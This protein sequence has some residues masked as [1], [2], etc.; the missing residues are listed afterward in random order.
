MASAP[1]AAVYG[2]LSCEQ[3]RELA[4]AGVVLAT[5][6]IEDGQHQPASLDLRLGPTAYRVRASFL[7]GKR[8]SVE[9]LLAELTYDEIGL[10]G[11]GAVLERGCVYVIPL[12]ESLALPPDVSGV[13]NPKSS[14]G[15]LDIF[16]RL[17]TD[18]TEIFDHVAAGYRGRLYAE[19]SPRS[20]SV[21]VRQGSRLDQLRLR[22]RDPGTELTLS[23]A[24]L[25]AEHARAPLA[26]GELTLRDGLIL[27]V[28]LDGLGDVVGY[29][30]QKHTDVIDVD[31]VD[32]YAVEDY[33]ERLT[34][35]RGRKLILDPNEFYILAS[36]ERIRIPS[37][38]SAEMMA[39]DPAMGEFRVHYAGF[40]DPG[41]GYGESG[42][43]GSRA[44]LEVRSHDVPFILEDGQ[45]IGRLVYEPMAA[46]PKILYGQGGVSNYQGQELKLSKHFK[47]P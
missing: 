19:V 15:R 39:I 30:A 29:R 40:F 35:R 28:A 13:A 44:V 17:I 1:N 21:R 16:T 20:F 32:H 3:I 47:V 6:P 36:R 18:D 12:L 37:H 42:R 9:A 38:L 4:A 7:P 34:P 26:D 46:E 33:W 10:E 41:F 8:R 23:D 43:P 11:E 22:R 45:V 27:R 2:V 5:R 14:T 31:R 25:A 24:A